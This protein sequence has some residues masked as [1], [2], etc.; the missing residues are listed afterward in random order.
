MSQ[1]ALHCPL[2]PDEPVNLSDSSPETHQHLPPTGAN[3]CE[4]LLLD[5]DARIGIDLRKRLFLLAT[6]RGE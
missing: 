4:S 2:P 3:C 6:G 5:P 1:V